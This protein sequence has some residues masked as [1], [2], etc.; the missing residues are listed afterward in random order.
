MHLLQGRALGSM[1]V[2][3]GSYRPDM[4]MMA[5]LEHFFSME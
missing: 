3:L 4:T 2:F 1:V 5:A